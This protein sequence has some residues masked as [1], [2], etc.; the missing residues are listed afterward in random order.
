MKIYNI[1]LTYATGTPKVLSFET[2]VISEA[3]VVNLVKILRASPLLTKVS[4]TE[5]KTKM[6][7]NYSK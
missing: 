6:V 3:G 5:S 2:R 4:Y 7:Q 1:T